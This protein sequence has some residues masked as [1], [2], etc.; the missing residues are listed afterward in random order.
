MPAQVICKF[1]KDQIKMK[2]LNKIICG[3]FQQSRANNS[4]V[5]DLIRPEFK[6]VLISYACP[7]YLQVWQR[8][9]Q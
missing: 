1:H 4:K 8:S 6:L 2:G 9:D 5:T 3:L 7:G